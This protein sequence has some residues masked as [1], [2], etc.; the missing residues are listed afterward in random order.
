MSLVLQKVRA[1]AAPAQGGTG[2]AEEEHAVREITRTKDIRL[3]AVAIVMTSKN[4]S[5]N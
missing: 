4:E 3:V 2:R 1:R 5:K